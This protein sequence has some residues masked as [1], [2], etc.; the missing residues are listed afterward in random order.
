VEKNYLRSVA[1]VELLP[2]AIE[3]LRRL[4]DAGLGL[5]IVSNQSAIGRGMLDTAG[6]EQIHSALERM[7][8]DG[9]VCI[10]AIYYCPHLP[11]DHCD[12]RKPATGM[13]KRAAADFVF[14]PQKAFVIGDKPC[15]IELGR[16]CG[17]R[18][19]LVRTGYG[20]KFEEAGLTADCVVDD[21]LEAAQFIQAVIESEGD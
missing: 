8:L 3:G 12:C 10:E 2:H 13:M 21:L 16:V 20:R 19:V 6:V 14:D 17:A 5:V 9:G 7:L 4:Q 11:E 15:D 18:T 1:E